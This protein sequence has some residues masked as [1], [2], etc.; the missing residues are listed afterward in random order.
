MADR[1]QF[2]KNLYLGESIDSRK[3]D[4]IKRNIC[5]KPLLANVYIIVPAHNPADQLDIFDAKQLVQPHYKS[6]SFQVIGIASDYQE[7]L[8]I[9]EKIVVECL[10]QTGDCK[11]RE[12]LSCRTLS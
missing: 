4:R 6:C 3:V 10:E 2:R 12:Y 5:K 7:A 1:I 8:K 11:L 9:I